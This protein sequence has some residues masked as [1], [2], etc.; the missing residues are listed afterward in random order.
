MLTNP[1]T[2]R[3]IP[4]HGLRSTR[5]GLAQISPRLGDVGANLTL[6]LETLES[7]RASLRRSSWPERD[8]SR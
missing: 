2:A 4:G 1:S 3:P 6:H 8:N 5:L 7:A